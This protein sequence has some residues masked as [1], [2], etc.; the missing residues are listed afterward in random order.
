[1]KKKSDQ[2]TNKKRRRLF[3]LPMLV[4]LI[5][6]VMLISGIIHTNNFYSGKLYSNYAILKEKDTG[7]TLFK[8][9][10][11]QPIYPASL[12]KIMTAL[13]AIETFD[14]LDAV[15][16]LNPEI[17]PPLYAQEASMAGFAPGET[18]TVQTL[19]YGTLLASGAECSVALAEAAFGS[20]KAFVTQMNLKAEQ[21]GMTHTV[22]KNVTGLDIDG[23]YSTVADLALLLEIALDNPTFYTIFTTST[24]TS[25]PTF[26]HPEGITI[27]STFF[28]K[29]SADVTGG[30]IIGAKTGYTELAVRCLASAAQIGGKTFI[31]VTADANGD[32]PNSE[33]LPAQ[34]ARSLYHQVYRTSY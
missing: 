2:C 15:I 1:M 32:F 30:S 7:K 21:I 24:Y 13:I 23:Q 25:E 29:E 12:T 31:L 16:T 22:F 26:V 8:R 11:D 17:F 18:L 3:G 28:S 14:N 4:I 10:A 9:H 5:G 27:R 20:E 6:F 19:L 34:D 33:A